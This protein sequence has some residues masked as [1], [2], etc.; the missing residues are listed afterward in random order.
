MHWIAPSEND[1]GPGTLGKRMWGAKKT[2]ETG[3]FCLLN[4]AVHDLEGDKMSY[5]PR[6]ERRQAPVWIAGPPPSA[7]NIERERDVES[8]EQSPA[9]RKAPLA[10][11]AFARQRGLMRRQK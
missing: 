1:N 5:T 10:A 11:S 9:R 7:R 4:L 6:V 8:F 2:D 3:I